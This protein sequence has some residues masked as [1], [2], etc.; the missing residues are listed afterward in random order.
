MYLG[1]DVAISQVLEGKRD[2]PQGCGVA[3]DGWR[4]IAGGLS[5]RIPGIESSVAEEVRPLRAISSEG[6][7]WLGFPGGKLRG[8]NASSESLHEAASQHLLHP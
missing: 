6:L 3:E 4:C 8:I 1:V 5:C 2:F 7:T